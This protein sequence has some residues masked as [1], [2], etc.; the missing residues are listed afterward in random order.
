MSRPF[1][2]YLV[3][4][5]RSFERQQRFG[6]DVLVH[7]WVE[8]ERIG[9][10]SAQSATSALTDAIARFGCGVAV[11]AVDGSSPGAAR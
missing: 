11:E 9:I 8:F 1:R 3:T 7:C 5:Q 4:R 10:V 6:R 2:D